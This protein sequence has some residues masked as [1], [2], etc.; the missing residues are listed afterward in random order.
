MDRLQTREPTL[1]EIQARLG[2]NTVLLDFWVGADRSATLWITNSA[3]GVVRHQTGTREME[4]AASRLLTS[5][6]NGDDAWKNASRSLGTQLLADLPLRA[7][8]VAVP[9]GPLG[10]VPLELL[11]ESGSDLLIAKHDVS[12]LPAAAFLLRDPGSR[13]WIPPW[14]RQLV[15]FGDPPVSSADSFA[16]QWR[17]LA[18]SADEVRGIAQL[19]PGGSHAYLGADARKAHL[20]GASLSGVPLLHFSTHAMV[21][22][23][24]PDRSRILLAPDSPGG[25]A[26]YLFEEEVYDLDLNG[27]EL[28]TVSACDTARGKLIRGEGTEAFSRAFLAAG[29]AATITSL[30]RVPD[31]PTADF[32]KQ[33]Y[34]FL[35]QGQT[36]A[37][38]LRMAKLQFLQP[39]SGLANPRYWAAFVLNGDG[40]NSTRRVIPWSA[41]AGAGALCLGVLGA[42]L[43]KIRPR[44]TGSPALR[45]TA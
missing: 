4:A 32:M 17:P 37:E 21:D 26:D 10:A 2:P 16:E 18:A 40:W 11:T 36:K 31:Q 3:A 45:R 1:A 8:V 13:N 33:L 12:Y 30:W 34:Y 43:W 19:L 41:V 42:A 9:D 22:E 24:N 35:A 25:S 5:L 20:L 14:R 38:A 44:S 28:A 6:E 15:A 39:G 29:S 23:E 27:V 7:H